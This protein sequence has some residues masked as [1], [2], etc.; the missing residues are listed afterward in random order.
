MASYLEELGGEVRTGQQISSLREIPD[1]RSTI[2]SLTPRQID[3][4]A[5]D[6]FDSSFRKQLQSW[7]YGPAAW[8]VDYVLD[9]PIPWSQSDVNE[10]GT[11]HVGGT[12]DEV[13][14]AETAV[15]NGRLTDTPFVLLAQHTNFDPTRARDGLHTAW[16]YCH[17]PNGC[18]VDQTAAIESQIERFAPGFKDCIRG[19][20]VSSPAALE[21]G[22]ANLVGGDIGGGSY[23]GTQLFFRPRKHPQPFDTPDPQIFIGSASTT[24]GAGVHGMSGQGAALRTLRTA[25]R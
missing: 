14:E 3:N 13:N 23:A 4:I 1:A 19:R 17:V 9:E 21:A 24:P 20:H 22:N 8:K 7:N 15:A 18:T 5:G 16:A 2:L 6:H 12:I 25:L 11:V 10:A